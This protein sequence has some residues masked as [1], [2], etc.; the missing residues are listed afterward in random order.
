MTGYRRTCGDHQRTLVPMTAAE[1][2]EYREWS[3]DQTNRVVTFDD[4]VASR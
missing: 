3:A 1:R 2:Q 4:W